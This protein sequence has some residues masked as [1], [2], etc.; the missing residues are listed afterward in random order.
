MRARRRCA[1][2]TIIA[3]ES[4]ARRKGFTHVAG[5]TGR[6]RVVERIVEILRAV[7]TRFYDD[8]AF[9]RCKLDGGEVVRPPLDR[10]IAKLIGPVRNAN[11]GPG[12]CNSIK[13]DVAG[14]EQI[15][16][17]RMACADDEPVPN[18]NRAG[19]GVRAMPVMPIALRSPPNVPITAVPWLRHPM[20]V[21]GVPPTTPPWFC[22]RSS[23][24]K[25][26]A[27]STSMMRTPARRRRTTSRETGIDA[28]AQPQGRADAR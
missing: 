4:G 24:E 20:S 18:G 9:R 10:N 8:H 5:E 1:G 16:A 7:S 25:R 21:L 14:T 12:R 2:A 28:G 22:I 15:R 17:A 6:T 3:P 26:Q 19:V 11:R 23:C 13:Y 27:P